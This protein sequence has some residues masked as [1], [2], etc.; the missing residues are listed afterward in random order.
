MVNGRTKGNKAENEVCALLTK[1]WCP[2]WDDDRIA[3]AGAA[4]LPFR[5]RFTSTTPLDGT[6][7]GAGDVLAPTGLRGLFTWSVEVKK[8][9]GWTL[10]GMVSNAKWP[11]WDW[12]QQCREQAIA[13]KRAPIL[14]FARNNYPWLVMA[15]RK[16]VRIP[17]DG[18]PPPV[19]QFGSIA[20]FDANHLDTLLSRSACLTSKRRR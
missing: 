11:V 19:I 18:L 10:D 4:G 6:W 17:L 15:P 13:S 2:G 20:V 14:F 16:L 8:I 1:W 12:W 3:K 7:D 9:E 5:R